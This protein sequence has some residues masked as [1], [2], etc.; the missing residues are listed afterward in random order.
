M[1]G[2]EHPINSLLIKL[3]EVFLN[4]SFDE[5]INPAIIDERDIFL[6]YGKEA[7]L[8]LDRVFYIAGLIRPELGIS[9]EKEDKILQIISNFSK[10]DELKTFL[11]EYK[12]G[13]IESDNFIEELVKRLDIKKEQGI[14]LTDEV[15][16]PLK[17]LN[18]IPYKKTLRSHMTSAWYPTLSHL[19]KIKPLPIKLFSQGMRFRREQRQD[20]SHLFESTIS[21]CVVME[22]GFD[23]IKGQ[24]LCSLILKE[25]GFEKCEFKTKPVASN[26]YEEKTD[27]EVF[28]IH[29][30]EKIE[31]ANLGFY[32]RESLDNYGIGN[33]VFNLGFGVDRLAGVLN[34]ERDLRRLAFFQFYKPVFTDL[35]IAKSLCP[36]ETPEYGGQIS[37]IIFKK[38]LEAKDKLGPTEVL[39]YSGRF[40]GRDIKISAYNWDTGKPLISYAGLNEIWVNNGE[41]FGLPRDGTLKGSEDVYK[42]GINTGLVFLKLITDGFVARMEKAFRS[43]KTEIDLKFKIAERPSDINLHIPKDVYE[44]IT[45]NNKRI[46]VKG[47]LFFGLIAEAE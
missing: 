17:N 25:I 6:Q 15:F 3:R 11:R 2:K 4:L 39:C 47:P 26:Y 19:V 16:L 29:N 35:E 7:S 5:V 37:S 13:K 46:S 32:S 34:N 31:V 44:Y 36:S 41:I 1:R 21:S 14:R 43:G 38:I 27:T 20:E 42:N 33:S 24:A 9:K 10:W 22:D 28:I 23:I 40:L 45:S 12:E 8:I 18:P 30:N